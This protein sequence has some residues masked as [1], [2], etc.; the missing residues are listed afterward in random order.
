MQAAQSSHVTIV[1]LQVGQPKTLLIEE[2]AD[3]QRSWT[4]GYFKAGVMGSVWLGSVNLEG[5][6]Q[7]DLVH[8]GGLNKAICVYSAEHY[9]FWHHELNHLDMQHG[10][11]GENFTLVG[12]TEDDVSIGDIWKVGEALVEVSQPRQPCWKLARRW[13]MKHLPL[14]VQQTGRTGWYLR[15]LREGFIA[16]GM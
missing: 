2:S 15:V 6:G 7:A 3:S 12:L 9:P 5:D 8:H 1:S 13:K 16:P 10:A 11:F 4:T 14:R